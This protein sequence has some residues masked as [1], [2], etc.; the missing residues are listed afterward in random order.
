[1]LG[2]DQQAQ[3]DCE[4]FF[5]VKDFA[6]AGT[7]ERMLETILGLVRQDGTGGDIAPAYVVPEGVL[8]VEAERPEDCVSKVFRVHREVPVFRGFVRQP[9]LVE[10]I[11]GILGPD[12]D[13]F[14]S[15][16]IFKLPGALGQP[17]H[18]D[19]FYFPFDRGPQVGA[20]LALTETTP[21][22]GPLWVL[23]RSHTEPLH[24]VVPDPREHANMA[25]VEIVDHDTSA[26]F[27]VLLKPGDL[28]VFHSHLFHKSSD[29]TSGDTRAAMVYHFG[30]GG[31]VDHSQE[32][33]GFRPPNVDWMPVRRSS[34]PL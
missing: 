14:L 12:V 32:K 33:W 13:C 1:V 9:R 29:N 24:D 27:P 31:T 22:N 21:E 23:P 19:A 4:G 30:A 34:R 17:W 7:R 16:F 11:G 6:D 2:R 8:Q 10:L 5:V 18:Q 28:I 3:W 20:W 15:Q 25:Y 26:A